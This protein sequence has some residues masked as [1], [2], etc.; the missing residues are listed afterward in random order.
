MP[1]RNL[2]QA[3]FL[4]EKAQ[5]L[6]E[7]YR[8]ITNGIVVSLLQDAAELVLWAIVKT[9]SI[10]VKPREG[11]VAILEKASTSGR[12]LHGKGQILE[13]NNSRI[14]FKHYGISPSSSDIPRFIEGA[15]VFL[16]GN[17]REFFQ[18]AFEEI[19]LAD[20]ILV[21]E[22]RSLLKEA[23]R[24]RNEGNLEEAMVQVSL[25]YQEL[26]RLAKER[27]FGDF[28]SFEEVHKL[29]PEETR[30]DARDF[31]WNLHRFSER[32]IGEHA[33]FTLNVDKSLLEQVERRRLVVNVSVS[34]KRLGVYP[35]ADAE[36]TLENV[37]FLIS[38]V[39]DMARRLRAST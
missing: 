13:I 33:M 12:V 37:N 10:D 1:Q 6:W 17:T 32:F 22:L 16:T 35:G 36:T 19:S 34:G 18:L 24:F 26:L 4:F 14:N 28:P 25:A 39:T 5:L 9:H 38:N 3:R 30:E 8:D 23:E 21:P 31:F 11:F 29:F 27:H 15:R 2:I 20:E 7:P